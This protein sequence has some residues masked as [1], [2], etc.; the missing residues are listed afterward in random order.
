M[1]GHTCKGKGNN[2]MVSD[3]SAQMTAS[4][5]LRVSE[6]LSTVTRALLESLKQTSTNLIAFAA[7]D[8]SVAKEKEAMM[9]TLRHMKRLDDISIIYSRK[10][11]MI[12]IKVTGQVIL[13]LPKKSKKKIKN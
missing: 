1:F 9:N 7:L 6:D 12:K 4:C 10:D 11:G 2:L 13:E 5:N 8:N 3:Y